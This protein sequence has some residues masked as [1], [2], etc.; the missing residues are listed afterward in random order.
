LIAEVGTQAATKSTKEHVGRK[1]YKIGLGDI[2]I[3]ETEIPEIDTHTLRPRR[4]VLP[5]SSPVAIGAGAKALNDKGGGRNK[6]ETEGCSHTATAV[7]SWK[8]HPW[9][10][11]S[12]SDTWSWMNSRT[13]EGR[14]V[15]FPINEDTV[16]FE[17]GYQYVIF[18]SLG[19]LR[20]IWKIRRHGRRG[21]DQIYSWSEY[22]A[23]NHQAKRSNKYK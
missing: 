18:V 1:N 15:T 4:A 19:A 17:I 21:Y 12:L 10:K 20:T 14:F 23:K 3:P 7:Y 16:S 6:K 11:P 2:I 8:V 9:Y 5:M 13:Q 22:N